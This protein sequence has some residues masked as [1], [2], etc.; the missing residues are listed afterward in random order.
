MEQ[1]RLAFTFGLTWSPPAFDGDA[2]L[3]GY[4]VYVADADTSGPFSVAWNMVT[5]LHV[6]I[7]TN[8]ARGSSY[9]VVGAVNRV[10][11]TNSSTQL[12]VRNI[13]LATAPVGV[14]VVNETLLDTSVVV[15]WDVPNDEGDAAIVSYTVFLRPVAG[16]APFIVAA[17]VVAYSGSARLT[18]LLPR[19]SY[20]TTVCASTRAGAGMN[21]SLVPFRTV[22]RPAPP[23]GLALPLNDVLPS[24]M[25]AVWITPTDTGDVALDGYSLYVSSVAS[26]G[27][28]AALE[29]SNTTTS[30]TL[31][32][33]LSRTHYWFRLFSRNRCGESATYASIDTATI[34]ISTQP[35]SLSVLNATRWDVSLVLD[36]SSPSDIGG[37]LADQYAVY[38]SR[39]TRFGPWALINRVPNT[40]TS[41]LVTGLSPRS[42]Y[43]LVVGAYTRAGASANS[44]VLATRTIALPAAPEQVAVPVATLLSSTAVVSWSLT[45]DSGDSVVVTQHVYLSW[46][47]SSGPWNVSVVGP[48]VTQFNA[49]GLTFLSNFWVRVSASNRAGEGA[50]TASVM[51]RTI[52]VPD[53]PTSVAAPSAELLDTSLVA[54]Y[55]APAFT[56]EAPLVS[57]TVYIATSLSGPFAV[58]AN[59]DASVNDVYAG[60][61]SSRTNYFVGVTATNRAGEGAMSVVLATRTIARPGAPVNFFAPIDAL[62]NTSY[63]L[64]WSAPSDNGD[65][66]LSSYVVYVSA[67]AAGPFAEL[68]VVTGLVYNVSVS[69]RAGIT[70]C[71]RQIAPGW[72]PTRPC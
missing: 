19:T 67:S 41:L 1:E 14:A 63:E 40:T 51:F 27:P 71:V 32:G 47:S 59:V 60:G 69:A 3:L 30:A 5:S 4:N 12:L 29:Y 54:T 38:I 61:L 72:A 13:A 46:V 21:S 24:S 70:L 43:W 55:M 25:K 23:S 22:A 10:G 20:V 56:G 37:S 7:T 65:A 2:P 15:S 45:P 9:V 44:S 31:T 8:R 28:F 18:G 48:A 52:R 6:V 66:S 57:F 11:E 16:G 64:T 17:A 34:A 35:I 58:V 53:P 49:T 42:N 50:L 26:S 36:W 33:L 62:L 39:E 68:A